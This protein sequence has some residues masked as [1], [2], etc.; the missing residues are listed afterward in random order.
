MQE[1]DIQRRIIS[2]N[3]YLLKEMPKDSGLGLFH[4]NMGL[5]IYF[6]MQYH[7]YRDKKY[8]K[9]ADKLLDD[10]Y[11]RIGRCKDTGLEKGI[12]GIGIGLLFLLENGLCEGNPNTVLKEIDDTV[13]KA[14][15]NSINTQN[16]PVYDDICKCLYLCTRMKNPKLARGERLLFSELLVHAFNKICSN[17]PCIT[18]S[19][20]PSFSP[21]GYPLLLFLHLV[22]MMKEQYIYDYK[23]ERTMKEW[24]EKILSIYPISIGHRYLLDNI[25]SRMS[26]NLIIHIEYR[27]EILKV[28]TH[29]EE[30]FCSEMRNM[31]L[32]FA[33]GTSGLWL[34]MQIFEIQDKHV[35]NLLT[36]KICSSHIW[37]KNN[38]EESE[39]VNDSLFTGLPGIILTYQKL[40]CNHV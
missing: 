26:Q 2:Y 36:S 11:R 40:Y 8:E 1:E 32:S 9:M 22:E 39:L 5:C 29:I 20:P 14:L 38:K 28:N 13:F 19:E 7:L 21:F 25:I 4:G 24:G 27:H 10:I 6:Y 15:C 23:I 30:F 33:S 3:E 16:S 12:T 35:E 17:M 37:A 31:E 18:N 34:F